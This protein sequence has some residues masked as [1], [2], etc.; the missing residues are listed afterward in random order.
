MDTEGAFMYSAIAATHDT[1]EDL[2]L[3]A[4]DPHG[5][6]FGLERYPEFLEYIAPQEIHGSLILLTNHYDLILAS[7]E[8]QLRFSDQLMT[9]QSL[10]TELETLA[11]VGL[12]SIAPYATR[13]Y[14]LLR[15]RDIGQ[16]TYE[17]SKWL[18]Y[19]ELYIRLMAEQAREADD[20]RTF[21]IKGLDLSDNAHGRDALALTGREKNIIKMDIWARAGYSL[22][23][24]WAPLNDHIM[25]VE[26]DALVH[27]EHL[28]V[29][30][31]L[32]P[33][34]SQDFVSSALLKIKE[35]EFVFY[36]GEP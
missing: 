16:N 20:F 12:P 13:M 28:I 26:E 35:L 19:R 23:S 10:M 32:E 15:E 31:F 21:E 18:C 5:H 1:I 11:G 6:H 2:L 9:R 22:H 14:N 3:I 33:V 29:K 17:T 30:D 27:A 7:I 24:A 36:L 4:S 34:S 8:R 25:E